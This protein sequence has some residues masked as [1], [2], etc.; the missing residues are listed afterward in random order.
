M[1]QTN[2]V[3]PR[4]IEIC[5]LPHGGAHD[6]RLAELIRSRRLA[7]SVEVT[8]KVKDL[9]IFYNGVNVPDDTKA[10]STV[11]NQVELAESLAPTVSVSTSVCCPI[12]NKVVFFK[13]S[14]K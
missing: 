14:R 4:C 12:A 2:V 10:C 1:N 13:A 9:N 7:K 3:S 5:P 6:K 8:V 11:L